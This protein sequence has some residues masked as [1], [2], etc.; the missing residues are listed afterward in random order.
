MQVILKKHGPEVACHLIKVNWER[1]Q[2]KIRITFRIQKRISGG[3]DKNTQ[4]SMDFSKNWGLWNHDVIE[5]FLQL[6]ENADD[7]NAPYLEVQVSPLNQPFALLI[8]EPRKDFA[9]P[10]ILNFTSEV[11][12]E[13]RVWESTLEVDL[14]QDL[15]GTHLYGGFFSCLTGEKREF[16][17]LEPNPEITPDFHRPDLF[18]PLDQ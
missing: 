15:E 16:F 13:D 8:K 10:Q 5:A 14:P 4:F 6:R 12:L 7:K 11:T 1:V 18:L 3:W 17:A 2:R 9:I